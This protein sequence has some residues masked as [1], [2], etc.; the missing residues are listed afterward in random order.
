M[1]LYWSVYSPTIISLKVIKNVPFTL[2]F[3]VF[4]TLEEILHQFKSKYI[5]YMCTLLTPKNSTP[6]TCCWFSFFFF[7]IHNISTFEYKYPPPPTFFMLQKVLQLI[8]AKMQIYILEKFD[9]GSLKG[10]QLA[11]FYP[12]DIV[13]CYLKI[14]LCYFKNLKLFSIRVKK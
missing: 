5:V 8:Y 4:D 12:Q 7:F 14:R 11:A 9:Q 10:S 6:F 1:K 3:A 13:Y 2:S